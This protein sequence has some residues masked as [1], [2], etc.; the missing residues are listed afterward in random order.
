MQLTFFFYGLFITQYMT[1]NF[2]ADFPEAHF[3][4]SFLNLVEGIHL[5]I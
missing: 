5:R 3:K 4:V 2:A 1:S